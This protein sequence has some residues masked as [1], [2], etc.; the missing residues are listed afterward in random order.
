MTNN[1]YQE[2]ASKLQKESN[3]IARY[4]LSLARC[5][6]WLSDNHQ[7]SLTRDIVVLEIKRLI[8]RGA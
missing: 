5:Y 8:E 4:Y 3:Y 1:E 7:D 6:Q 2:L